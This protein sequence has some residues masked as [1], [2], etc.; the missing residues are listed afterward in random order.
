M[1]L[2]IT[3][4]V[5]GITAGAVSV[6]TTVASLAGA[7]DPSKPVSAT[8]HPPN[9]Q[10]PGEKVQVNGNVMYVGANG[11]LSATPPSSQALSNVGA[12][13]GGGA[14]SQPV[15]AVVTSDPNVTALA[16]AVESNAAS[17]ANWEDIAIG[18]G[19]V[20]VGAA[21]FLHFHKK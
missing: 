11:I 13:S 19:I 18:L 16:D 21:L 10:Y 20:S 14:A 5:V 1:S 3:A 12:L 15:Q 9:E 8:N 6:G 2:A 7:F 17:Q 4:A